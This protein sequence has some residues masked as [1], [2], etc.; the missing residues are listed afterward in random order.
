MTAEFVDGQERRATRS[1]MPLWEFELT[2]EGLRDQT[3]NDPVY[4][5]YAGETD[6][7]QIQGLYVACRGDYGEF[8][9]QHPDDYSR[10]GGFIVVADGVRSAYPILKIYNNFALGYSGADIIGGVDQMTNVYLDGA[11]VGGWSASGQMLSFGSVIPA[12]V[13][14]TADFSFFYRCQF[15]DGRQDYNQFLKNLWE[16]PVCR[17]RSVKP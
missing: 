12:G 14:I 1:A 16:L 5:Q 7:L 4:D 13:K 10:E 3:L 2:F 15:T 11:A 8:Y 6:F 9:Y 17:F